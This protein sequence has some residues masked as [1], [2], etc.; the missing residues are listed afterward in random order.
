MSIRK[1]EKRRKLPYPHKREGNIQVTE[2]DE[3]R[4]RELRDRMVMDTSGNPNERQNIRNIP[5]HSSQGHYNRKVGNIASESFKQLETLRES[6]DILAQSK[7]REAGLKKTVQQL[8]D[9]P[10]HM[11]GARMTN[12]FEG[13]SPALQSKI[14][15]ENA[16]KHD[17]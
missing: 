14:Y 17:K 3:K 12:I 4:N 9:T 13:M 2:V 15:S 16:K 6:F 1:K 5:M 8:I 7:S 11:W 10:V